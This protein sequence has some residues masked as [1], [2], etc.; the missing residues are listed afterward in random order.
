MFIDLLRTDET[1]A[2]IPLIVCSADLAQLREQEEWLTEQGIGVV[3]K[4]FDLEEL[5]RQVV[6][7][8]S[9]SSTSVE[10]SAS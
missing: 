8:L 2:A 3:P 4:P 6:R 5:E 9:G 10:Q 1:T 7:L